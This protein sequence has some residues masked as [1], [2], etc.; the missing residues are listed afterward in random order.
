M[1]E[2]LSF[3]KIIREPKNIHE[4]ADIDIMNDNYNALKD[5]IDKFVFSEY[6]KHPS[7]FSLLFADPDFIKTLYYHL[8]LYGATNPDKVVFTEYTEEDKQKLIDMGIVKKKIDNSH[9]V[10]VI[11]TFNKNV[12][13]I[14]L[15]PNN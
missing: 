6:P 7:L 3:A 4:D 14:N 13:F 5:M 2:E 11:H 12:C 9:I 15:F 10:L 1:Q 8:R